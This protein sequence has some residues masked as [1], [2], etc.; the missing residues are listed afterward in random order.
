M[1]IL[2]ALRRTIFGDTEGMRVVRL[3]GTERQFTLSAKARVDQD[4]RRRR[5]PG[6]PRKPRVSASAGRC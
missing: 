2:K 5:L 3:D 4:L 6:L 1:D